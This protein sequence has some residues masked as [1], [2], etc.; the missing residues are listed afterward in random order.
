MDRQT[1]NWINPGM[2]KHTLLYRC[3]FYKNIT[4]Q[5]GQSTDQPTE[6]GTNGSN[7]QIGFKNMC[8]VVYREVLFLLYLIQCGDVIWTK[9]GLHNAHFLPKTIPV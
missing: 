4:N 7:K 8:I 9:D 1:N 6:K 2:S 5:G 3:N